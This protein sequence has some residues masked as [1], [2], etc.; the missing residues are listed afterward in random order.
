M[1]TKV[2]VCIIV[3]SHWCWYILT[4]PDEFES[5][6]K[7]AERHRRDLGQLK[8]AISAGEETRKKYGFCKG[9]IWRKTE[10]ARSMSVKHGRV[11]GTTI[12]YLTQLHE[13]Y[14]NESC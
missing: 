7:R 10:N 6:S 5:N 2:S 9:Q 13:R 14:A 8:Y 3:V 4:P 12:F 11:E 1:H